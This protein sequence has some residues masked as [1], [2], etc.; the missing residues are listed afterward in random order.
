VLRLFQRGNGAPRDGRA[1]VD[2]TCDLAWD[3]VRAWLDDPTRPLPAPTKVTRYALGEAGGARLTF[4][5][6]AAHPERAGAV[7]YLAA[8]E[9]SPDTYR[10]GPVSGCALGLIEPQP[11]GTARAR[12]ASLTYAGTDAPVVEKPEGLALDP[13]DPARAYVVLDPDDPGIP[14]RL[15]VVSLEGPW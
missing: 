9:A 5:D 13:R 12:Y 2:A 1:P 3:A 15:C 14:S 11:D 8:A 4:T 10:D 6:A 7:F